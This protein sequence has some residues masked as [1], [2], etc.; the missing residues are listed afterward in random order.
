M[1]VSSL[2][3]VTEAVGDMV[4]VEFIKLLLNPEKKQINYDEEF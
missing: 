1:L 2:G 3:H 4:Y